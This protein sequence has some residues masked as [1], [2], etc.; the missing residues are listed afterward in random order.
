M[1]YRCSM[2]DKPK[3]D[4]GRW[5]DLKFQTN[6]KGRPSVVKCKV[7]QKCFN[8]SKYFSVIYKGE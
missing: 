2:C 5:K 4:N 8:E 6:G 3:N 1:K 7:C